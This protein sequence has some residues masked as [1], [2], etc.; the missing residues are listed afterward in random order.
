M[1]SSVF[2]VALLM[3]Q[4]SRLLAQSALP[5]N[6]SFDPKSVAQANKP[7]RNSSGVPQPAVDP[8]VGTRKYKDT[9]VQPDGTYLSTHL[10]FDQR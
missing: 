2:F 6:Q 7:D 1:S 8:K 3:C 9:V 4:L 5:A 10:V